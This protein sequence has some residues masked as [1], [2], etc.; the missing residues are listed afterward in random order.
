MNWVT[1]VLIPSTNKKLG[2]PI[3]LKELFTFLGCILTMATF[4]GH[5]RS[6]WWSKTEVTMNS[7]APFRLRRY[8]SETRFREIDKALTLTDCEPPTLI[9]S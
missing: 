2:K 9:I 7:G 4:K 3:R 8:M 6:D 1:D 5:S